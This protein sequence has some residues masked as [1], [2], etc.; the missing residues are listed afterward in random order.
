MFVGT[1]G[2]VFAEPRSETESVAFDNV[3]ERN[4]FVFPPRAPKSARSYY[5]GAVA[6]AAKIR[7]HLPQALADE[8]RLARPRRTRARALRRG[9]R[10]RLPRRVQHVARGRVRRRRR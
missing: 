5:Y 6:D 7:A 10:P 9:P 1:H 3:V 2:V 8:K 4:A